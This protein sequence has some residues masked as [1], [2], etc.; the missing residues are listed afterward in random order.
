VSI[1][2]TTEAPRRGRPPRA[3]AETETRRRRTGMLDVMSHDR[4]NPFD[5]GML[6]PDYMYRWQTDEAG[7]LRALTTRDDY[8]FVMAED[9]PGFDI[10]QTDSESDGRIRLIMNGASAGPNAIYGYLIRKRRD[11]W[12]D[13]R[14]QISDFY[15]QMME[16]RVYE[17]STDGDPKS[18]ESRPGGSDKFYAPKSNQ[19]G[20]VGDRRRGPV[21]RSLK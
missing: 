20:T 7:Q 21:Q 6:D 17:A 5:E 19:I 12:E 10:S 14:A 18:A 9:L 15:Q 11:F 3:A 4:L 2:D 13:D 8:D 16:G 1:E